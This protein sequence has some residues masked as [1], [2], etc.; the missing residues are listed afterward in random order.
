MTWRLFN[1]SSGRRVI[2]LLFALCIAATQSEFL[3]ADV[4]DAGG[5]VVQLA[6]GGTNDRAP[7]NAPAPQPSHA[8]H[9][10][11]CTHAHV[12][13]SDGR[14]V[15]P[16]GYAAATSTLDTSGDRMSSLATSPHL[17]PPIV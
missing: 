7:A 16:T 14:P 6:T 3:L 5:S 10:D 1:F 4:H 11:H 2:A 17:R 13:A 9:V 15:E 8:G 12:F